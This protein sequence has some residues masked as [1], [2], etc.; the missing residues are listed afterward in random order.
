MVDASTFTHLISACSFLRSREYG[1]KIHNHILKFNLLP[2]TILENHIVNMYGKCGLTNGSR[3]VFDN[4]PE[5]TRT[6][7]IAGYSQN[8]RDIEALKLYVQMQQSACSSIADAG[9]GG[10]LH[11]QVIKSE[12]GSHLIA[13]NS[14]TAM[15]T[16][17]ALIS[18][19]ADVFSRIKKKDLISWSSMI[20]RF[21][22]LGYEFEA[23]NCLKK[24]LSQG[25]YIPNEFISEVL[26]V[27][28]A[29]S[30]SQNMGGRCT[31]SINYGLEAM[32]LQSY[33]YGGD[34]NHA[35]SSFSRMRHFATSAPDDITVRSLLCGFTEPCILSQGKQLI[36][37]TK[38]IS[39]K[40]V[41]S[42]FKAVY[43]WFKNR[44]QDKENK[45]T[46]EAIDALAKEC[47]Q[48]N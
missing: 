25:S 6:S 41:V 46:K 30:F 21:S 36:M 10:Q 39:P 26:S 19:S 40:D 44:K 35:T 9:L 48:R 38:V 43:E 14:L 11:G 45:D 17:F 5:V 42:I 27:L 16:K 34:A 33:P 47:N 24:M 8:G 4:M 32:L 13:Q 22:K 29:L 2:D 37:E 31:R 28:V 7:L 15:Y 3:K 20:S 12:I 23:L 1:R 18:E